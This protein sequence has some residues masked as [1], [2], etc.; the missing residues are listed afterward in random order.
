MNT[1]NLRRRLKKL[2]RHITDPLGLVPYSQKWLEFWDKQWYE[3]MTTGEVGMLR[4]SDHHVYE[5]VMKY[6]DQ[7][8]KSLVGSIPP[9]PE[10]SSDSP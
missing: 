6:A 5:A 4:S 9:Y 7:S 10:D 8:P 2:E 3:Y 1:T